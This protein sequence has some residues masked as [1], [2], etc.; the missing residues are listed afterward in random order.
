M[1][2]KGVEFNINIMNAGFADKYEKALTEFDEKV[3]SI[4]AVSLSQSIREQIA[5]VK[6]FLDTVFGPEVYPV[7]QLDQEDL[8]EHLDIVEAIVDE[9]QL[10]RDRALHRFDKYSPN[11]SQ[12]HSR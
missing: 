9:T 2:I 11:R 7:L 5:C 1:Q 6:W 4:Q 8:D 3:K 10:Q 12:R